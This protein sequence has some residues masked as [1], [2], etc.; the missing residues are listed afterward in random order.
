MRGDYADDL[1]PEVFDSAEDGRGW[2]PEDWHPDAFDLEE[3][4][5][6]LAP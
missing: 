6:L 3:T 4:N 5:R 1:R 2:L